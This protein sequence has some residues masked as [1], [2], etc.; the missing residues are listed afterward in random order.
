MFSINWTALSSLGTFAAVL[1]AFWSTCSANCENK[2]N[3]KLQM[4][5][6]ERE[7][8]QTKLDRIVDIVLKV[9]GKINPLDLVSCSTN[10]VNKTFTIT[11]QHELEL[12]ILEVNNINTK[13]NI[14]LSKIES[15][16]KML[17][18]LFDL[19]DDFVYFSSS[20]NMISKFLNEKEYD[21]KRK[22]YQEIIIGVIN[23]MADKCMQINEN[24][25]DDIKRALN[26]KSALLD[27]ACN[28]VNLFGPLI[29]MRMKDNQKKIEKELCL[30]AKE[31]QDR[32]DKIITIS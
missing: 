27:K 12:L 20:I 15:S 23:K 2:K 16:K 17:D 5:M 6:L 3:R 13:L 11:K 24:T 32:I 14:E 21:L 1:I 29:T 22:D 28:L 7:Y 31:Q 4:Q 30:F 9:L 19:Q 25:E 10:I 18:L 8:E 26:S